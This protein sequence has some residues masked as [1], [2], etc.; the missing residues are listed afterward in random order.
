[1]LWR[2]C[3]ECGFLIVFDSEHWHVSCGFPDLGWKLENERVVQSLF[4]FCWVNVHF[5]Q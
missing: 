1:M 2:L 5:A 4:N 3:R